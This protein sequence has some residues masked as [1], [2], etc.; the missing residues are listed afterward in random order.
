MRA[1]WV[2]PLRVSYHG[3]EIVEMPPPT[4]GVAALAALGMLELTGE[5]LL[6]R[7]SCA[8]LALADAMA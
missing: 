8:R 3:H 4:Q 1:R 2:T 5:G 6:D 7:I